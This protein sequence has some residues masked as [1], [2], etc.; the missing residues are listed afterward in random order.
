ML[1]QNIFIKRFLKTFINNTFL[2]FKKGMTKMLN[3]S[4]VLPTYN[5]R[6]NIRILIPLLEKILEKNNLKGEIIVV[7]DNSPDGTAQETEKLKKQYDNVRLILR[8]KKEGIGSALKSGYDESKGDII[9]SMDADMSFDTIVM[10]ELINQINKG[11]GLVVGQK[12]NYEAQSPLKFI[13]GIIS[14]SGNKFM[15]LISGIKI[16][17]FTANF[18]AMKKEVWDVIDTQEKT[19]VFLFEMALL[20]K[21]HG[22][23]IKEVPVEFKDRIHGESKIR[24]S[25]EIPK[26]LFKSIILTTKSKLNIIK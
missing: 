15:S 1:K 18:R 10:L 3:L 4:I 16:H 22:F 25:R 14:R 20:A 5:E 2:M 8:K 13:Q 21:H 23:K 6:E 7:D 24:I 12:K 26:F 19:N 17:D 11:Y 9:L